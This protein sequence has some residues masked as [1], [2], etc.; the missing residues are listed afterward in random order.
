MGLHDVMRR[1]LEDHDAV[2]CR[3]LW[4]YVAPNMPQPQSDLEAEITMHHACTQANN[5]RFKSRAYSHHWL[6]DHGYPS[7]LPDY[8]RPRA[9]RMYPKV[10]DAVGI[11]VSSMSEAMEPV[12][13]IIRGAMENVV[14]E[15]YADGVKNPEILKPRM[16][17]ARDQA[18][19]KLFG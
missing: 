13:P 11:A 9:E 10:V 19:K 16:L 12:I 17:E 3:R 15:H 2:T 5:I 1:A 14:L 4:K 8:L 7:G 6:K 18:I